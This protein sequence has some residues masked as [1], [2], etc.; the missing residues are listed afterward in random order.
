MANPRADAERNDA[1][2]ADEIRTLRGGAQAAARHA[3]DMAGHDYFSHTGRDG[4]SPAQR[5]RR[6]GYGYRMTGEN[7]AA[8]PM[9]PEDAMAGWITSPGH[10]A[11]LMNARYTEMGVAFTANAQ[12]AMGVY[13]V[14]LFGLPR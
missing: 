10:C 3:A 6:A 9:S 12:S 2:V 7:I 14:Q 13:W 11:N 8:G 1:G 5:V 4:S